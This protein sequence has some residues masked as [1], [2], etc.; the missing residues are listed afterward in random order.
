MNNDNSTPFTIPN[1]IGKKYVELNEALIR[2]ENNK[3]FKE[4]FLDFY[5]KEYASERVSL[6][7]TF[8][9]QVRADQIELMVSIANF[10]QFMTLVHNMAEST[11]YD[12]L[13]EG[14]DE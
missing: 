6:M 5:C 1:H 4:V 14:K 8:N 13:G 2:L 3:D 9:K 12:L 7:D 11:K 10:Q